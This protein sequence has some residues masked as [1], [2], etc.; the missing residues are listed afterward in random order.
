MKPK[1]RPREIE[2]AVRVN[3]SLP[4]RDYDR[5]ETQARQQG[6]TVPALI[7]LSVTLTRQP[8]RPPSESH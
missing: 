4:A 1:G 6:T 2:D 3:V 5:L 7:R 8:S